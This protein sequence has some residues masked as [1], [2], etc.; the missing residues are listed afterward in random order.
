LLHGIIRVL[1][2]LL[3][4]ERGLMAS[5][6]HDEPRYRST[7]E[8][9]RQATLRWIVVVI[10]VALAGILL[11]DFGQ[12][13]SQADGGGNETRLRFGVGVA[14]GGIETYDVERLR[15]GWNVDWIANLDPP[16]VAGME[17]AQMVR[18][19][20]M[21]ECWPD[22]VEGCAYT[23]PHTYT[24][25]SPDSPGAIVSIAQANPGSLWLIGNEMDRRDWNGGGQDE[26]LPELYAVAYHELHSLIKGA[27]PTAQI[28]IGG[29]VQPT[30]LRL[31]YLDRVLDEYQSRYHVM[32]PVDVW[33]IHNMILRECEFQ[34][35][36]EIPPGEGYALNNGCGRTYVYSEA[37]DID[38]FKQHIV[39]FREWMKEN[40]EQD[41]P[42]IISEY[43]VLY[44]ESYD[45]DY[46]RVREYLYATLDYMTTATD[47][48]LGY[49][50]DD[51][52]LVQR[53][54]WYSLNDDG[55][56]GD[57]SYHHF[58]DPDTKEITDL[59]IDYANY[60]SNLCHESDVD[61]D[62]DV[63]IADIQSVANRWRCTAGELCYYPWYDPD[64]DQTVTVVDIMRVAA[65]WDW[66]CQ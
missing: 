38:K 58:F 28:A 61:C 25:T 15:S 3:F 17:Y 60:I 24:L 47:P 12:V 2:G 62:C 35:G 50:D 29:V 39:E 52:R 31:E 5:R 10:C 45:Y 4:R 37:D 51:Y 22:R 20:Q 54:A 14:G 64:G 1:A 6:E 9:W 59:G 21:T 26:M 57:T 55:F 41:K 40:G 7:G 19:H 8:S 36:A 48:S 56:E 49:P 43:S 23:E 33:N 46:P 42:L 30:P 27:D 66:V 34:D 18:L 13:R 53:W 16:Q 11:L 65:N 63:D 32:I 44:G